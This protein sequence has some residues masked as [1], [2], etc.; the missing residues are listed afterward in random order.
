MGL[1]Q[2][3][4][5]WARLLR[6]T[7]DTPMVR[8]QSVAQATCTGVWMGDIPR[9]PCTTYSGDFAA[10]DP[11]DNG[12]SSSGGS[13]GNTSGGSSGGGTKKP[14]TG[15][16]GGSTPVITY[17]VGGTATSA[18]VTYNTSSGP[19]ADGDDSLGK[20]DADAGEREKRLYLRGQRP[21]PGD[22]FGRHQAEREGQDVGF[23]DHL[24]VRVMHPGSGLLIR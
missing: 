23:G 12:G 17:A 15:A 13:T 24:A 7:T 22:D 20:R 8:S 1:Y 6:G 16:G 10:P 14:P 4:Q 2:V 19:V 11:L 21:K 3:D 18:D 5:G 9:L